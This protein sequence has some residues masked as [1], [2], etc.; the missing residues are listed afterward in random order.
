MTATMNSAQG[1]CLVSASAGSGKTHRLTEEVARSLDPKGQNGIEVSSLLAV[2]YTTKAQ[3]EL[4]SRLR[5]TLIA[6]KEFQRA[7]ELPLAYVGTVHAV[8]LRLLDEFALEA[9]LSPGLDG[10][11]R[12]AARLLLQQSLERALDPELRKRL[13]RLCA[14]LELNWD[15]RTRRHD[16]ITP[17]DQLM[18]LARNN[19]I[20]PED[21]R[22]MA[23]RSSAGLLELLGPPLSEGETLERELVQAI[24]S[25]VL[26]LT[27]LNDGQKNTAE[28]VAVLEECRR[29]F[30][31]GRLPWSQWCKLAKIKPGKRAVPLVADVVDLAANFEQHPR[32][33]REIRELCEVLFEAASVGLGAYARFKAE[34]GLLDFVDMIDLAL[35]LLAVP[36]VSRELS[37]RLSLLVVDEFQDTSPIQLA[38]FARLHALTRRSLWVGDRKQCIFEYAGADPALMEAVTAWAETS[39]GKSEVL[40]NN[41]RSRPELV[42]PISA[43]FSR[44]FAAHGHNPEEVSTEPQRPAL[45]ELGS[46]PGFSLWWLTGKRWSEIESIALGVARLLSNPAATPVLDRTTKTVR[47]LRPGDIAV[48]VA[49]NREAEELSLALAARG[50]GSALARTGLMVTPEASLLSAALSYLLDSKN[51][52]ASAQVEALL[53]FEGQTQEAWLSARIRVHAEGCEPPCCLPLQQL[54]ALRDVLGALS[55][56]EIVMR[57]MAKLDLPTLAQRWPDPEQRLGNLDAL[58]ALVVAY[59]DRATYL[60][61]AA[62]LAGLLR[63]FDETR[64][65]VWQE[66]EERATDEQHVGQSDAT[67]VLSTYH[68]AKGLEWPVVVLGSLERARRR[69][70][71]D[72]APETDRESF[73]A[74]DPLGGRWIRYWPWPLGQQKKTALSERA[75]RSLVGQRVS[76]R[77]ARE[78]VRLLYVGFTRARDHLILALPTD[79]KGKPRCEW[80]NE[81]CDTE[82][83]LLRLPDAESNGPELQL[84]G[85]EGW[86]T[87]PARVWSLAADEAAEARTDDS[88]VGR[89]FVPCTTPKITTPYA[90]RPSHA[91]EA[92]LVLPKARIIA[93]HRFAKRMPFQNAANAQ[94]DEVGSAL[95]AFLAADVP[96]LDDAGRRSLAKRVLSCSSLENSFAPEALLEAH[97]ELRAFVSERW[98]NA[99]WQCEIPIAALLQTEH[100]ERRVQGIIDLLL[101]TGHGV[102]LIDHKSYPGASTHWQ[103]QALSHAPQLLLYDHALKAA[104]QTVLGRFVHFTIG[105]GMVEIAA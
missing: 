15:G 21:L 102:V 3:A 78:R 8:C 53:G 61:E 43:L 63:Y 49:S 40:G 91:Q 14:A 105:G 85:P 82:G 97:D 92:D 100:G 74:A 23:K 4:E 55:P 95:H 56:K 50:V 69:D 2:T 39:G 59:E 5:R 41:Y 34:R 60:R 62:S 66:D 1:L 57:V 44:A 90:L 70:A 52:L 58:L 37:E 47:P 30:E 12:G 71:F 10:L 68:K 26:A 11:P 73:N 24:N 83:P 31:R 75:E 87:V 84:R 35:S 45:P 38:L 28:V 64:I 51:T 104:G 101:D 98:P 16:W 89:W 7:E 94:W 19:R 6:Q 48:L 25:A 79:A 103:Q 67:V 18:T 65:A 96:E 17:V 86:S 9:G 20:A 42:R 46:L 80:L 81:L 54:D 93:V 72:V 22:A 27:E 99:K 13:N 76:R 88:E 36:A 33:Q 32:F 77:D 29:E